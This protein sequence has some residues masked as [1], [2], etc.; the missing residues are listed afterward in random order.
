MNYQSILK[1]QK[2]Y[3]ANKMQE[4]INT[5][6]AWR[7]EGSV[8]RHAMDLLRGGACMLPKHRTVDAY[9]NTVPSRY[10]VKPGTPGS[11]LNCAEFWQG[12]DEGDIDHV[13]ALEYI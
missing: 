3:G 2:I 13:E 6:M 4:L 9:G 5:G 1:L 12:V 7:F 11:F 10:D 8:G